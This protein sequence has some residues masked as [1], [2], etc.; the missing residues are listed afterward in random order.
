MSIKLEELELNGPIRYK[1]W[2]TTFDRFDPIVLKGRLIKEGALVEITK[3]KVDPAR[4]FRY[5]RDR[6]GNEMSVMVKS[7]KREY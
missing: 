1:Y 3:T 5:V 4:K 7:L 2:P 6:L